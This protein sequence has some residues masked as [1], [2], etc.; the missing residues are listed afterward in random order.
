MTASEN[1]LTLFNEKLNDIR[2]ICSGKNESMMN[3]DTTM[4]EKEVIDENQLWN[5][6]EDIKKQ[7]M[8]LDIANG[9]LPEIDNYLRDQNNIE[10]DRRWFEGSYYICKR[11]NTKEY[12]D[13]MF[14]SHLRKEHQLSV[15]E[16]RNLSEFYTHF[17]Q[18]NISCKL[19]HLSLKHDYS[20][21]SQHI[22]SQHFMSIVDYETKYVTG[23]SKPSEE[24]ESSTATLEESSIPMLENE[25]SA[26]EP[27]NI[28]CPEPQV[29]PMLRILS[30]SLIN[31][32][33]EECLLS[34]KSQTTSL[35]DQSD[36]SNLGLEITGEVN[37]PTE[38]QEVVAVKRE[39]ME[40]IPRPRS[41]F[42]CPFKS[43]E[44]PGEDC[45]YST[46]KQGFLNNDVTNHITKVHKLTAKELKGKC[47]FRKVK[48]ER[49]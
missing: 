9:A 10:N 37:T 32:K 38:Q 29:R 14:R 24:A 23:S 28:P 5:M 39:P 1:F 7:V 36:S 47:K 25:A 12:G 6:F 4:E 13:T 18:L 26:P 20:T 48:V 27:G 11:C 41:L 44:N 16:T 15:K 45:K 49:E 33:V 21:L 22:K 40:H 43:V 35:T 31:G 19:C 2:D 30:P 46:T 8:K 42:Y 34:S 3:M 17:K